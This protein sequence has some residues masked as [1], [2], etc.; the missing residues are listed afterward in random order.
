[1]DI[2]HTIH[3]NIDTFSGYFKEHSRK[4]TLVAV[5]KYQTIET[6]QAC[7]DN[8]VLHIA[9]A[10]VQDAV[11][12]KQHLQGNFTYHMIGHLQSNKVKQ[13]VDCFDVIQSVD[14]IKLIHTLWKQTNT[15]KRNID[16][17]LQINLSKE[18]Q[19]YWFDICEITQAIHITQEYPY[20]HL[21]GCMCMW[22]QWDIAAT[23]SI[24]NK[25]RS[26]CNEHSLL[27]CSMGMSQDWQLALACW[28]TMLRIWSALF[29]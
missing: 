13:A 28:S 26:I 23:K 17:L 3:K 14:S 10:K 11:Y 29:T 22:T 8:G 27:I 5:T 9:E 15:Q 2:S 7:I 19:K 25:L 6:T 24:F 1:M 16:I 20:L 18:E 4:W 21:Q 12:K